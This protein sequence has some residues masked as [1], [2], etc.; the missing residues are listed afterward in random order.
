MGAELM[1]RFLYRKVVLSDCDSPSPGPAAAMLITG[2]RFGVPAFA[3]AEGGGWRL[4]PS[5]DG[6]EDAVHYNGKFHSITYTGAVQAWEQDGNAGGVFMSVVIAPRLPDAEGD[7]S[8]CHRKYLVASPGGR[9]MVVLKESKEETTDKY[10]RPRRTCSFKVQVLDG[11]QWRET[12]DIGD[13]ALFVGVNSSLC[14][15]TREHP[16]LRAGC[17]YYT[18]N[19]QGPCKDDEDNG[20][21]V[22]SLKDG[23][24]EKVEG[25]GRHRS[26]PPLAWFI[27][28]I[29]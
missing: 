17:I 25:L 7:S 4:A 23:R 19:D 13:A 28:S 2:P 21:G 3:T 5:R 12:D 27:P 16:E 22:F 9:Q 20:A 6:V 18:E 29:P 11:E 24:A 14:M 8:V 26:W 15:S 10:S 1:R